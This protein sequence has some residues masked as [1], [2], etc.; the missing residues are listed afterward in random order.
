MEFDYVRPYRNV[1]ICCE[2]TEYEETG[3]HTA[4]VKRCQSEVGEGAE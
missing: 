2:N 3:V 4:G 1:V